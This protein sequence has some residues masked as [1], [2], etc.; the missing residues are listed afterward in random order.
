M[1]N[2]SKDKRGCGNMRPPIFAS[3]RRKKTF[4]KPILPVST[5]VV[6]V[7][8]LQYRFLAKMLK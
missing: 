6:L 3:G 5:D 2:D 8:V 4:E 1:G 7:L